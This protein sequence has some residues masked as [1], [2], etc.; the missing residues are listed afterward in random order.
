MLCL[1]YQFL[2]IFSL[3]FFILTLILHFDAVVRWPE[4]EKSWVTLSACSAAAADTTD[5]NIVIP[6]LTKIIRSEITFVSRNLR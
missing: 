1:F 5:T 6:R 3:F 4:F 2:Y